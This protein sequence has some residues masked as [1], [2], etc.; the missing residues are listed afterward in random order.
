VNSINRG[1]EFPLFVTPPRTN[2]PGCLHSWI[3]A[4]MG[5]ADFFEARGLAALRQI[6]TS[7][8]ILEILKQIPSTP[9]LSP[10]G[11]QFSQVN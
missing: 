4:P 8:F 11:N 5:D 2:L 1:P 7:S 9:V 10:V 6:T 3:R